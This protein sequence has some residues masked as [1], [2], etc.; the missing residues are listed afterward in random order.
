[1]SNEGIIIVNKSHFDRVVL[2]NSNSSMKNEV[3]AVFVENHDNAGF[4]Q[5]CTSLGHLLMSLLANKKWNVEQNQAAL[6]EVIKTMKQV[7]LEN[8][9]DQ[10]QME[11]LMNM[12]ASHLDFCVDVDLSDAPHSELIITDYQRALMELQGK[13]RKPTDELRQYIMAGLLA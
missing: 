6:A 5:T 13:L 3:G 12:A 1:M 11:L 7:Q 8:H 4:Y 2:R 10:Q 9:F